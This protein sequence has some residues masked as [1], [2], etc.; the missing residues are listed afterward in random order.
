MSASPLD[1]L[2]CSTCGVQ[3]PESDPSLRSS[4]SVCDDPRQYVAPT[5]QS[6]TTLRAMQESKKYHNEF[7]PM[8]ND[9]NLSNAGGGRK[10][11]SIRTVPQVAIGQRA[12]LCCSPTRGNNILWDCITYLDEETVR[13]IK[14]EFGGIK[15]IVISHPHYFSTCLCWAE[16]FDCN[17]YLSAEDAEWVM[18]RGERQVLWEGGRLGFLSSSS[19]SDITTS[20]AKAQED[21]EFLAVKTGGHFP[22]SSVLW[23][24]PTRKLLVAD[25]IYVV[26]S[27]V[28]HIDRPPNTV[29]FTFMW[30]YP[31]FIPLHPSAI[32]Q[33]WKSLQD[34]DFD[35]THAAFLGRDTR[36]NSRKRVLGSAKIIVKAMGYGDHEILREGL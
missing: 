11:I 13:Y 1:L 7:I 3:Y 36:G 10:L 23:W 6:W 22:G 27:G 4:C 24:K 33:I 28:Y 5:G 17:V 29:S 32:H 9:D 16:A 21:C 34:L 19:S 15:A 25:T 30:S 8:E 35:D 26:P 18:R 20:D 2:I 31:N 14:E 12:I